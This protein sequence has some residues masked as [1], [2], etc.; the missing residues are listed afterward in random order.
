MIV[1]HPRRDALFYRVTEFLPCV[2]HVRSSALQIRY[3]KITSINSTFV[4]PQLNP[5]FDHL[6]ESSRRRKIVVKHRIWWIKWHYRNKKTLL[7][8]SPMVMG[9]GIRLIVSVV[10]RFCGTP[11]DLN[12]RKSHWPNK[13]TLCPVITHGY[14][15]YLDYLTHIKTLLQYLCYLMYSQGLYDYIFGIRIFIR[16]RIDGVFFHDTAFLSRRAP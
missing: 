4:I 11:R 16:V 9:A 13:E 7:I 10:W 5:M 1:W 6:L 14:Y 12:D 3:V 8:W 15:I 2:V